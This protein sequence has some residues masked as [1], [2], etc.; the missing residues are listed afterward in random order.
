MIR[1][2]FAT[3]LLV[4]A[5]QAE[6]PNLTTGYSQNLAYCG[7]QVATLAWFYQGAVNDGSP[8]LQSEL[9]GLLA[10]QSILLAQVK[11]DGDETIELFQ[12]M[13]KA[14][15]ADLID[16]MGGTNDEGALALS[17]VNINVRGC[18]DTFFEKPEED[19]VE[20]PKKN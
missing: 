10:V 11:H 16:Q 7:S 17:D 5:A 9:D 12:K 6:T 3:A 1:L 19:S 4:T 2:A 20:S 18:V 13:T 14:S 8:E 15:V